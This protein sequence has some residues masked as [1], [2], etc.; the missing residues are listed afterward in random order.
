[1]SS[2]N[3]PA[4]YTGVL[5]APALKEMVELLRLLAG[6]PKTI[7]KAQYFEQGLVTDT[8]VSFIQR[9]ASYSEEYSILMVQFS[10]TSGRGR[11]DMTGGDPTAAGRGM[12]ILAGGSLI[13]VRGVDNINRFKMIAEVGQSMQYNALLF[14]AQMWM[15]ERS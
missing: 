7:D 1:M 4:G 10:E 12:P 14:K 3:I 5:H 15:G 9:V 6:D 11:F 8:A 13:V 2:P